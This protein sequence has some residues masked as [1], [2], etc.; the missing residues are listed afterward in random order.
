[1]VF[2]PLQNVALRGVSPHDAGVAGALSTAS[3]QIGGSV[4]LAV[5]TTVAAGATGTAMT[6]DALV[7]GYSAV[8]VG[9]AGLMVLGAVIALVALPQHDREAVAAEEKVMV[10]TGH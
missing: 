10:P 7:D 2:L 6:L 4:G 5:W 9:S 3:M 8:F 1:M